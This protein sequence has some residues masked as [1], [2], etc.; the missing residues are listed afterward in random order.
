MAPRLRKQISTGLALLVATL[1]LTACGPA[2]SEDD[3]NGTVLT[4]PDPAPDFQLVNQ[5][6][7]PVSLDDFADRVVVL[8]FLYTNC[9]DVCPIVTTQLRDTQVA[10]GPD[11]EDVAFIAISTD[12]E[13]DTVS[14]AHEYLGKWGLVDRW[15]YLVG[16]RGRLEPVWKEYFID[17]VIDPRDPLASGSPTPTPQAR[18]AIDTLGSEIMERYLII[19]SAPVFLIDREGIRRV[20]FTPPLEPEKLAE[21]I[22]ALLVEE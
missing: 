19:H 21:D 22:R 9:P 5:F 4:N 15:D 13:R 16:D 6:D 12:P 11:A 10:L 3:F 14:A 2:V 17:P 18:G 1:L 7:R 8:T 20:V